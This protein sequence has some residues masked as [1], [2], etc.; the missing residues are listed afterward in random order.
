MSESLEGVSFSVTRQNAGSA[1]NGAVAAAV[2]APG[3]ANAP[4]GTVSADN[5]CPFVTFV[6]ASDSQG[7]GAAAAISATPSV[8]VQNRA[9]EAAILMRGSVDPGR[10]QRSEM[11]P[12][13]H[14]ELVRPV[15]GLV[16]ADLLRRGYAIDG[17]RRCLIVHRRVADVP[18]DVLGRYRPV[19][20]HL[21]FRTGAQRPS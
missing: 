2:V 14:G 13:L 10:H 4:A 6:C 20:G 11:K 15:Q 12:H 8:A 7:A 17:I 16:R 5:T 9:I 1:L 19:S 21:V 3:G 18:V